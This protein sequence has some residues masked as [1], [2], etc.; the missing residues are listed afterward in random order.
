MEKACFNK[1]S[2]YICLRPAGQVLVFRVFQ[3]NEGKHDFCGLGPVQ[4]P[5][6]L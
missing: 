2:K 6:V 4:T 5:N 3:A 1:D